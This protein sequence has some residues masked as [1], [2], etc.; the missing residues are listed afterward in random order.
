MIPHSHTDQAASFLSLPFPD[1]PVT[2]SPSY[3]IGIPLNHIHISTYLRFPSL[4]LTLNSS[5]NRVWYGRESYGVTQFNQWLHVLLWQLHIEERTDQLPENRTI[6][7]TH[8]QETNECTRHFVVTRGRF[9]WE[10]KES[11]PISCHLPY[12]FF[13]YCYLSVLSENTMRVFVSPVGIGGHWANCSEY[14]ARTCKR[15]QINYFLLYS[16]SLLLPHSLPSP[17]LIDGCFLSSLF[18]PYPM[19]P[20]LSRV[21]YFSLDTDRLFTNFDAALHQEF[22]SLGEVLYTLP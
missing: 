19:T 5:H 3:A 8:S 22:I 7:I 10:E 14:W 11:L 12:P 13:P 18:L 9:E 1:I 4:I 16:R 2:N 21:I 15:T 20:P 6:I 17:P